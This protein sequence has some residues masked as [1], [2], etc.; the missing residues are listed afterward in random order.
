MLVVSREE[1]HLYIKIVLGIVVFFLGIG[2]L[3]LLYQLTSVLILFVAGLVFVFLLRPAVD[4][5]SH[6]HLRIR[7]REYHLRVPRFISILI[8]YIALIS[9][10]FWIIFPAVQILVAQANDLAKALTPENI[11]GIQNR[12]QDWV[13]SFTG[14]TGSQTIQTTI[15]SLFTNLQAQLG[16]LTGTIVGY[17]ANLAQ[18]AAGLFFQAFIILIITTF[19]LIDWKYINATFFVFIPVNSR[20]TVRNLM[21]SVNVQIWGYVKAQAALSM[22]TG[23]LVGLMCW[24]LGLPSALIIGI[25]VALG[26]MVPYIGPVFSF[27]IGLVLAVV[28]SLTGGSMWTVVY[29]ALG[30][31]VI[32]QGLAQAIAAPVLAKKAQVHPLLVILVMFSF[33][34]LFGP[35]SV[36]LAVPFLVLAKAVI[37]YLISG[38]KFFQR[39][40]IEL[41]S[42]YTPGATTP[43]IARLRQPFAP[44][45][46]KK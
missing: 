25:I 38:N 5:L 46:I 41:D 18:A 30:F 20:D 37:T 9:I 4:F 10:V 19:F 14:G 35:V 17:L 36:L 43:I 13:I 31:L 40:G 34:T 26:E 15:K 23:T 22:L 28:G 42:Y 21:A 44:R 39:L 32:E 45:P 16:T 2:L 12:I 33:Y 8:V 7:H 24:I 29:Y 6:G 11:G 3:Y 27:S 1:F